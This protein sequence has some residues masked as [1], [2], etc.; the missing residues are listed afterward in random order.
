ML[1]DFQCFGNTADLPENPA[2]SAS[3]PLFLVPLLVD[4]FVPFSPQLCILKDL[5][6]QQ[7]L[8]VR[9]VTDIIYSQLFTS[10][11]PLRMKIKEANAGALTNFEV[12]DFLRSRGASKDLT[13]VIVP[14]APSEFKVEFLYWFSFVFMFL[15]Y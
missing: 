15:W 2:S 1:T 5:A 14:I 7:T 4:L 8:L 13:R 12:L 3:I 10:L 11:L 6:I 9:C